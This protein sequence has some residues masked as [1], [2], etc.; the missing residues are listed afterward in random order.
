MITRL[1]LLALLLCGCAHQHHSS[2]P[3]DAE[4]WELQEQHLMQSLTNRLNS[5]SELVAA[6]KHIDE[7]CAVTRLNMANVQ[8]VGYKRIVPVF[9]NNAQLF[10]RR[11]FSQG[12]L[13]RTEGELD[14]AINGPGFF[15][16]QMPDGTHA[17]TRNGAF[18]VAADGRIC[19]SH[20]Y[21]V[22]SWQPKA[23]GTTTVT[24]SHEGLVT[25]FSPRGTASFNLHLVRFPAVDQLALNSDG[26]FVETVGSGVAAHG[27]PGQDG[28]GE[29]LQGYLELANVHV[30]EE[31]VRLIVFESWKREV[32]KAIEAK[33]EGKR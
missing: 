29:L 14:V 3:V 26:L 27:S 32:L 31:R 24:I 17:Y 16:V 20:G 30:V 7:A 15:E 8:T 6:V 28:F 11:S 12:E 18:R 25:Y 9:E 21:P 19:T 4:S 23:T 10:F 13:T 33:T 2:A 5:T 1:C 22:S